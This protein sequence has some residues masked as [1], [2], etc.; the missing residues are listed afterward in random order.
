ME[1]LKSEALPKDRDRQLGRLENLRKF[2]ADQP[3]GSVPDYLTG[4]GFGDSF[5]IIQRACEKVTEEQA[6]LRDSLESLRTIEGYTEECVSMALE[7]KPTREWFG[8]MVLRTYIIQ[9]LILLDCGYDKIKA[10][11]KLRKIIKIIEEKV[12]T[13]DDVVGS[14]SAMEGVEN[15]LKMA[16][17]GIAEAEQRK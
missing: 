9:Q 3:Q 17:E 11:K 7:G 4:L 16:E 5:L 12:L 15:V 2:L 10:G 8:L 13:H 6:I 1:Y 14:E